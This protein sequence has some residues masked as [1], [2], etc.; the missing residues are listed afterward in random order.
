[1]VDSYRTPV[2]HFPEPE[3][4]SPS[5]GLIVGAGLFAVATIGGRLGVPRLARALA[6][7]AVALQASRSLW[8]FIKEIGAEY[9]IG[10]Q[11]RTAYGASRPK[12]DE[13]GWSSL[14]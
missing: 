4:L 1:M 3:H 6:G 13:P 7:G 14:D 12:P 11:S 5:P 8:P 9:P 2:S 10:D